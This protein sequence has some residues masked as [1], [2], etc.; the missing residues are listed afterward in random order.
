MRRHLLIMLVATA[1]VLALAADLQI[2]G[3][4]PGDSL[5]KVE[6]VLGGCKPAMDGLCRTRDGN[7]GGVKTVQMF[8][9]TQGRVTEVLTSFDEA[10]ASRVYETLRRE[11][12]SPTPGAGSRVCRHKPERCEGW[13][14]NGLRLGFTRVGGVSLKRAT[15]PIS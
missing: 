6:K 14:R 2:S 4:Q 8:R 1:P 5:S 7:I 13:E 11:Y 9:I 15:P 3:F 10:S 12:G